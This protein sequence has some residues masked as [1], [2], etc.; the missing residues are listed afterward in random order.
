[1]VKIIKLSINGDVDEININIKTK[2]KYNINLI[3]SQLDIS[4]KYFK[5]Q[6]EWEIDNNKTLK[7]LGISQSGAEEENFHQLPIKSNY[8]FYGDLYVIMININI[9]QDLDL[10][11]Y[12][13]IYNALYF[14]SDDEEKSDESDNEADIYELADQ[15]HE[16][17]EDDEINLDTYGENSTDDE[18]ILDQEDKKKPKVVK[19]KKIIKI[20]ETRD[21]LHEEENPPEKYVI[22]EREKMLNI[23]L[24]LNHNNDYMRYLEMEI[25]NFAIRDSIRRNIVPTW[26]ILL[27]KIYVNKGRSLY[28]NIKP[29]SYIKNKQLFERI[30]K[31]EITPKEL[32]NMTSQDLFPENWKQLIDEKYKKNKILYETKKEAM[33]DQFKCRKCGSRETC[34]YEMQTRSADEPM[35]I[36][37]T[38]INCGN[39]WKN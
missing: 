6:H 31:Q 24:S 28:I 38:C 18:S 12:E 14:E 9:I 7:L 29:D 23:L 8:K 22:I 35:T 15:E 37:I 33:T 27:K 11:N 30:K 3:K 13:N 32:A 5:L 10:E 36:F 20:P 34:Y 17:D 26:N 39:R 2:E 25:L 16:D 1:M 21:I 4:S 19:K